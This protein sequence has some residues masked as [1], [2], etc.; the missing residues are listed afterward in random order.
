MATDYGSRLRQARKY[1]KLTQ[2]K[3]S[4]KTKIPQSTISTA[5]REGQ[6]SGETP[7]YAKACGVSAL[8][9]ATGEGD[10][11]D[12]API[13]PAP[14]VPPAN[15]EP[16]ALSPMANALA[17]LF[18]ML[19][20]DAVTRTRAYNRATEQILRVLQGIEDRPMHTPETSDPVQTPPARRTAVAR[21]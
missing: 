10:M 15:P 7:V 1:A 14:P 20:S 18:D 4:E 9:L 16:V 12:S 2:M 13:A 19:P 8:W 21:S 5:E 6:G 11:L 17:Q 3:L